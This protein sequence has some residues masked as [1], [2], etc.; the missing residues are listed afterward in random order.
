MTTCCRSSRTSS[1]ARTSRKSACAPWR[2]T[3]SSSA[4][5]ARCRSSAAPSWRRLRSELERHGPR[6]PVYWGNRNW[7]PFLADTLRRMA[8]DGVTPRARALHV[9]LRLVPGL[10]PV[11]RGRR[12]RAARGR[13]ARPTGRQAARVLQPPGFVE[14]LVERVAA[15]FAAVPE[16]RRADARL[17]FTAH[18]LPLAMAARS[19]YAA[20]L[21]ETAAL[22]AGPSAAR[23]T[24][25]RTRAAAAGPAS[26]GSSP[27]SSS[28]CGTRRG[29]RARR[30]GRAD[31]LPVRPHGGR[32][33]SRRAGPRARQRAG[34]EMVRAATVGTDPRFVAMVRELVLERV[35]DGPR[36]F[37]GSRGL[38]PNVCPPGCCLVARSEV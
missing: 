10:P 20:E 11:S 1:A 28:T 31:R 33:R 24:R 15:A 19:D 14:P 4:A 37:L 21:R 5:R 17:V 16:A 9:G 8:E 23:G 22:V 7:H 3:T 6:L 34:L 38:A 30:R 13:R 18:S 27:T 32:L 25:S 35:A 12:A 36:R 2:A 29:G 26:P